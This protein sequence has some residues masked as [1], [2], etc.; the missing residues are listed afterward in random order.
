MA[1]LH[2]TVHADIDGDLVAGSAMT[3]TI[4]ATS[5]AGV[6]ADA[7]YVKGFGADHT[8]VAWADSDTGDRAEADLRDRIRDPRRPPG[9]GACQ[10]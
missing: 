7:L 10:R 6:V 3:V 1:D 8:N 4:D 5:A 2:I 9:I